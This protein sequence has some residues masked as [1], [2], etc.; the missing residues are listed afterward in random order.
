MSLDQ[1]R[2]LVRPAKRSLGKKG[3]AN[4]EREERPLYHPWRQHRCGWQPV[5]GGGWQAEVVGIA[6]VPIGLTMERRG[7][8]HI[9]MD[10]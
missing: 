9:P 7:G 3:A 5:L 1:L 2:A 8:H 10:R 4:R 6:E